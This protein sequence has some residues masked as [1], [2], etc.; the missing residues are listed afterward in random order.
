V[1]GYLDSR[2]ECLVESADS[3]AGHDENTV[4]VFK[5]PKED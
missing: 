4:V 1:Q 3:V 2:F 5:D